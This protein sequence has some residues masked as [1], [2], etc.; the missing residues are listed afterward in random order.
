M[1]NQIANSFVNI[2]E[3]RLCQGSMVYSITQK[4]FGKVK[5]KFRVGI[6]P[7]SCLYNCSNNYCSVLCWNHCVVAYVPGLQ[8]QLISPPTTPV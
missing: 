3:T 5:Y 4:D 8:Q 2:L 7:N 6:S 1:T